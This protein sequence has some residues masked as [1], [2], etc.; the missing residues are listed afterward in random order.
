MK[1]LIEVSV[2]VCGRWSERT[3]TLSTLRASCCVHYEPTRQRHCQ[4]RWSVVCGY[5]RPT[6]C[7]SM[8][9]PPLPTPPASLPS[10]SSRCITTTTRYHTLHLT[11]VACSSN[12][13]QRWSLQ[14]QYLAKPYWLTLTR[15]RCT[16]LNSNQHALIMLYILVQDVIIHST[17][18]WML[19][20]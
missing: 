19:H 10:A 2:N 14:T 20:F 4:C 9:F 7:G 18:M 5:H 6:I 17:N 11:S 8:H 1:A 13:R 16:L 12:L 3:G 15:T